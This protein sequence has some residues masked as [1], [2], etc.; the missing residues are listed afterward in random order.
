M[1]GSCKTQL[2]ACWNAQGPCA[3]GLTGPNFGQANCFF[4]CMKNLMASPTNRDACATACGAGAGPNAY[5]NLDPLT[6][7][8][9]D[10]VAPPAVAPICPCFVP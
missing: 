3:C 6:K 10:C 4:D 7:A 9:V 5:M 2:D 8:I 1:N